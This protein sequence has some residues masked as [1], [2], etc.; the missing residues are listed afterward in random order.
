MTAPVKKSIPKIH[1]NIGSTT[2][3][4]ALNGAKEQYKSHG[5][6]GKFIVFVYTKTLPIASVTGVISAATGILFAVASFNP[7]VS[8]ILPIISLTFGGV[9]VV[10]LLG[11]YAIK[12]TPQYQAHECKVKVKALHAAIIKGNKEGN[13]RDGVTVLNSMDISRT[14]K[15]LGKQEG[16]KEAFKD[17][18]NQIYR[19]AMLAEL[20]ASRNEENKERLFN[21]IAYLDS[22]LKTL[23]NSETPSKERIALDWLYHHL[24]EFDSIIKWEKPLVCGLDEYAQFIDLINDLSANKPESE[25]SENKEPSNESDKS[26]PKIDP[27]N[28]EKVQEPKV[29]L[30]L[31]EISDEEPKEVLEEVPEEVLQEVDSK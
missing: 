31:E 15:I 6:L 20:S 14:E 7:P 17:T 25:V 11:R 8:I 29:E 16:A 19:A 4:M 26:D 2:S 21:Y 5:K 24:T 28:H 10:V 1:L 13:W 12:K 22:R 9:T 18:V 23:E 27:E 3:S 30:E